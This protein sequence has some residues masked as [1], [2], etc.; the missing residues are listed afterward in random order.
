MKKA[1]PKDL[2]KPG[3][4]LWNWLADSTEGDGTEP[5]EVEL[6]KLADRLAEVRLAIKAGTLQDEKGRKNQ[7]LDI[8]IKLSGQF[9]RVWRTLG[10]A[11]DD[12]PKNPVGRPPEFDRVRR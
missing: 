11:D 6:C 8:E 1:I 9:M 3:R 7:L 4:E 5:L 12:T 2:G 10:L